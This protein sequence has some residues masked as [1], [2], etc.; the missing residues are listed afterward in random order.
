MNK[1]IYYYQTFHGLDDIINSK[2]T[3]VTDIIVASIH[4]G[5][6]NYKPYIHLN[7]NSPNDVCFDNVWKQLSQ[8]KNEQNIDIHLMVGGA[9][10]AFTKLFDNYDIFYNMLKE[11]IENYPFISGINLD[12]EESVDINNIIK[13]IK[14]LI[15]DFGTH[16]T[17][18]TAPIEIAL[19][20]DVPGMGGF[21]YKDLENSCVG[22]WIKY[23]L[24]QYYS[25][26]NYNS[27]SDTVLNGWPAEKIV[28]GMFSGEF[29][30][31]TFYVACN[32][33]GK[34][35][36]KFCNFGGVFNWE[37]FDSPPD[38]NDPSL[39]AKMMNKAIKN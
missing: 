36:S 27:F 16:F 4:F 39:W 23:Y 5:Y 12:I 8:L 7:D 17:I 31:D 24:G 13:L 35:K 18:S 22:K 6:N 26:F 25:N 21:L 3:G 37:Y 9:G 15:K 32:E 2:N 28:M 1:I 11:T 34:I 38:N 19:I 10:G 30:Y 33:V 29:D 20:Y 14:Q